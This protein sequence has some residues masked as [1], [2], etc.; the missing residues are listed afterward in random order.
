M[1]KMTTRQA[2]SAVRIS[3]NTLNR[4]I[5]KGSVKAPKPVLVGALGMRLWNAKEISRLK[6]EKD[7]I[8]CKGRGRKKGGGKRHA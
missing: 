7:K 5:A 4:W 1:K 3:L 6:Q 8:Y 2:A